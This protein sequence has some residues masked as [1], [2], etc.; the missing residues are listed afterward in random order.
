MKS[1]PKDLHV[2]LGSGQVVFALG[3]PNANAVVAKPRTA[4][5][6]ERIEDIMIDSVEVSVVV[7]CGQGESGERE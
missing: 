7:V 4:R 5:R 3:L 2:S 1:T 6:V